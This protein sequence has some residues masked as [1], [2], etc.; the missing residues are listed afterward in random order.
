MQNAQYE[1]RMKT[2]TVRNQINIVSMG[3]DAYSIHIQ[4]E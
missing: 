4:I 3:I 1:M 2:T